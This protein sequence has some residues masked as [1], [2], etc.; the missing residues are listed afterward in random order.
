M[1]LF[2]PHIPSFLH[3]RF[4]GGFKGGGGVA[5]MTSSIGMHKSFLD[6]RGSGDIEG[7]RAPLNFFEGGGGGAQVTRPV[8]DISE[9]I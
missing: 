7:A 2:K 8:S 6:R 9:W 5:V 1:T 4:R 3:V